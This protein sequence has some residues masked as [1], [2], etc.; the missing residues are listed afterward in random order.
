MIRPP[1]RRQAV[2]LIAAAH[3]RGA[4]LQAVCQALGIAVRT[5]Q[6]WTRG[7]G[8]KADARPTAKRPV[9]ANKL[10][11]AECERVLRLCHESAYASLPPG[12]IVPR[13][14][15]RGDYVASESSFY[16]LLRA[17][18]EQQHR[19]RSHPPRPAGE[20][21]RLVATAPGEVWTWDISWL[22]GPVQGLFFYL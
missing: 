13:L 7:G 12:Q 21:P 17:A 15:D 3:H 16:R 1:D 5:Y 18:G 20:P 8:V 19:G 14:A 10:T 22:P 2:A 9:P 11:P 6:R 4:R